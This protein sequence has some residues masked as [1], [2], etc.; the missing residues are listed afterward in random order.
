MPE[1]RVQRRRD[2]QHLGPVARARTQ[3]IEQLAS[4]HGLVGDHKDPPFGH[5]RTLAHDRADRS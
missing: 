3:I 2:D 4:G 1:P 5:G